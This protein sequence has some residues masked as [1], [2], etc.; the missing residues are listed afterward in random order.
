MSDPQS[1]TPQSAVP[2]TVATADLAGETPEL[3]LGQRLGG[4]DLLAMPHE[5]AFEGA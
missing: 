5:I 2:E 1:E 3:D 4:H